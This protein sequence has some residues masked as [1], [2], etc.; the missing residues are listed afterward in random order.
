[1]TTITPKTLSPSQQRLLKRFKEYFRLIKEASLYQ[2]IA[3]SEIMK[4]AQY[5]SLPAFLNAE[6]LHLIR[7][8]FFPTFPYI[9]EADFLLSPICQNIGDEL[10][11]IN[12]NI[13]T[14]LI[15]LFVDS[16]PEHKQLKEVACLIFA[17]LHTQCR[18]QPTDFIYKAQQFSAWQ[19]LAPQKA[20]TWL[21]Q[22]KV[23]VSGSTDIETQLLINYLDNK[24]FIELDSGNNISTEKDFSTSYKGKIDFA[25]IVVDPEDQQAVLQYFPSEELILLRRRYSITKIKL[26]KADYYQVAVL[27]LPDKSNLTALNATR[28]LIEDLDPQWLVLVGTATGV[29]G[30]NVTLGDVV[31]ANHLINFA[32]EESQAGKPKFDLR[33]GDMQRDILNCI[34]NLAAYENRFADWQQG[35]EKPPLDPLQ[36]GAA[37]FY[38]PNSWQAE[39]RSSLEHHFLAKKSSLAENSSLATNPLLPRYYMAP[40]ALSDN[41]VKDTRLA[42]KVQQ[43]ALSASALEMGLAGVYHAAKTADKEYPVLCVHAIDDLVGLSFSNVTIW[44]EYAANVAARLAQAIITHVRPI[45]SRFKNPALP[46]PKFVIPHQRNPLFTGRETELAAIDQALAK[47]GR[48]A[49]SGLA[50]I[51]KTATAI[52][53]AH[54]H[55]KKYPN[56]HIFWIIA[57]NNSNVVNSFNNIAKKLSFSLDEKQD[58]IIAKV[59]DWLEDH[60]NWLIIFD[61]LEDWIVLT[62]YLPTSFE[63]KV[64]ITSRLANTRP[65]A[66][67]E[68]KKFSDADSVEF[69]FKRAKITAPTAN[70]QQ[71]AAKLVQ[72]LD[73][74]PLALEQ[75]AAYIA[76]NQLS[77]QK[78]LQLYREERSTLLAQPS[79]SSTHDTVTV[80][81]KL[82][83]DKL[84]ETDPVAAD[85]LRFMAFLAPDAI[86]EEIFDLGREH[87]SE[88]LQ[89]AIADELD[90]DEVCAAATRYSL[91]KRDAT[92]KSFS[93]NRLVQLVIREMLAEDEQRQW[94]ESV[95]TVLVAVA[96]DPDKVENW[97]LYA[98]LVPHQQMLF[99]HIQRYQLFNEASGA[100][101]TQVGYYLQAQ[102][103][104][105]QAE[106]LWK[107]ALEI[108][109]Q[110]LGTNHPDY[111]GS[112]NNLAALYKSQGR[113]EEAEPLVKEAL[114][115][116][117]QV[118]GTLHPAYA[119]SLNN[120]AGLY[121]FQGRYEQAE[122]LYQEASEIFKQVLGTRHPD[123]AGSLHN[124]AGLYQSQGRYEEAEPLYLEALEIFKQ[125][126]GTRHPDYASSLNNL[127]NLYY[128]QGRYEQ[129]E[130]LYQQSLEIRKQVVGTNHPDY[131]QSLHNLANLYYSQGR[132]EQAEP[133]LKEGFLAL[134]RKPGRQLNEA[135]VLI[136]GEPTA[137]KTSLV[138]Q[139]VN[140]TFNPNETMTEGINVKRWP[141]KLADD[142]EIRLNIWDFG[143]Q[144]IM[145]A[146][147]QFFLTKRSLYIVMI[148][149]R[150]GETIGKL[151]YWLQTVQKF[152]DN[153]PTLLVINKI[154]LYNLRLDQRTLQTK[155]PIIK[156]FLYISC[157]DGR[158]ITQLTEAIQRE[159]AQLPHIDDLLPETWF[160]IK[161]TLETQDVDYLTYQEFERLASEQQVP[162]ESQETLVEL[163]HDLGAVICFSK[164]W[165]LQDTH[166]LNPE[167]ITTGVYKIIMDTDLIKANGILKTSELRRILPQDRYPIDKHRFIIE[168][169]CKFELCFAFDDDQD[170][171][172]ISDLFVKDAPPEIDFT[173]KGLQFNYE[174]DLLPSSIIRRFIVR[175]KAYLQEGL[176]WRSG[177]KLVSLEKDNQA[178]VWADLEKR[179]IYITVTGKEQGR[180]TLL[181]V[182]RHELQKIHSLIPN[183]QIKELIPLPEYGEEVDYQH[184][185]TC[186]DLGE[187]FYVLPKAR[188]KVPLDELLEGVNKSLFP[189]SNIKPN[190][191]KLLTQRLS[192]NEIQV[193]W[194]NIFN[195]E[196]L[197]NILPQSSLLS[198][199]I[200]LL[201]RAEQR[202]KLNQLLEIIIEERPDL[203]NDI[204][205][206]SQSLNEQ[207]T[208]TSSKQTRQPSLL[209]TNLSSHNHTVSK[210]ILHLSDIHLGNK[211]QAPI[212]RDKL[213]LDLKQNLHLKQLDYLIISGDL[214]NKAT[215]D[216]YEAA[217]EMLNELK[218]EFGLKSDRV[219]IAPGNHDLNWNS[220]VESYT[221]I[222]GFNLP[223]NLDNTYIVIPNGAL[224][225]NED[226]Y[227]ERFTNF[228]NF[229]RRIC[230]GGN[231]Y[232]LT[233]EDQ[234]IIQK[235]PEDKLLFLTLNSAWQIDH[236]YKNRAGINEQALSKAVVTI[237]AKYKD[238]YKIAIWHHPVTGP[239]TMRNTEFLG[240]LAVAGF[241]VC[242]HGHIYEVQEGF[243]Q[244]DSNRKLHIIG[245]GAF[246]APAREQVTGIP[247]Q[248]NLLQFDLAQGI[249]NVKTRKK[250][251]PDGD[252]SADARWG[253]KETPSAEY[254]IKISNQIQ[255]L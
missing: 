120:L 126:L 67:I 128:S 57:D 146:T 180:K 42:E 220:S 4:F 193:I 228:A 225:R 164:D 90:W 51:G 84:K 157:K 125:V 99:Q 139:L 239:A 49:L 181:Q 53:Y 12:S 129:A 26:D 226:Q 119:T 211:E 145:H 210:T 247:L 122:S 238:Y 143:G 212:Y 253:D 133:L 204:D 243:Y 152:S 154:D 24:D 46:I 61:N 134:A 219:I 151:D 147:H 254:Q 170:T 32:L 33:G 27:K 179:K 190:L 142:R 111:A 17:Y 160:N 98:R 251:K 171:L 208:T 153:S 85:L 127:A 66:R 82:S 205:A 159:L 240:E 63:G 59:K 68:I 198:A 188:K 30:K 78:Y 161:Q 242:L 185:L 112:L 245:G 123:Y 197:N 93:I 196:L 223:S 28:D 224:K 7:L 244:Y 227:R 234:A 207:E 71:F 69:L 15:Q 97:P 177:V 162:K 115:I 19:F 216:E 1:M 109:K 20:K 92:S 103:Q 249:I 191:A 203:K 255:P 56:E 135:K 141:F 70:D 95:V 102:G 236:H 45:A 65:F 155:Y 184:A 194:F 118:L 217:F 100:M 200:E 136:V 86:P 6:L 176:Y 130:P 165:R 229:Y 175:M 10:Y 108:R 58:E 18:W 35:L 54:R 38:G 74:L 231:S 195:G 23:E 21:D 76:K 80:T 25:I 172:L 174:Y 206:L 31:L 3:E 214:T 150:Q 77:T 232:P 107:E 202:Q 233:Y 186:K 110:V 40:I 8:N 101:L 36:L 199:I 189:G 43:A 55:R 215:S 131:A 73:S 124:L 37:N 163:L 75:A 47:Q 9:F 89:T 88:K 237:S 218:L 222:P 192:L 41:L 149:A 246:G 221:Y 187:Q 91:I 182:I 201:D 230:G 209:V 13:Q 96:Q 138:N 34:S 169:M 113:Y 252:W 106:P 241:E 235:F 167:W 137:G 11:E 72:E 29:P 117:K 144:E 121:E 79:G 60:S 114:E 64:L 178:L 166:I 39:V 50:G 158:G 52:E 250:E 248:Y 2:S 44:K 156:G 62:G 148:D 183:L 83:F 132:Y 48:V 16:D 105:Q 5:A 173:Q 104:Y 22:H 14:H 116:F 81:F 213:T 87:L 140:N 168:M 94:L